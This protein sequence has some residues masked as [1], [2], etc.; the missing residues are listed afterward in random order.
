MWGI[1][2]MAAFDEIPSKSQHLPTKLLQFTM[3]AVD[4]NRQYL[5]CKESECQLF[6]LS[7]VCEGV[8]WWQN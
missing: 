2:D 3:E 6:A 8:G 7:D 4:C 5:Q 1:R